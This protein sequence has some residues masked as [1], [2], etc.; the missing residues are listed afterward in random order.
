[1]GCQVGYL[2]MVF[3]GDKRYFV[4]RNALRRISLIVLG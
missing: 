3:K 4:G 1:M 2:M